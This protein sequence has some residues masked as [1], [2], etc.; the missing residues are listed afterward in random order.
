[1]EER[2]REASDLSTTILLVLVLELV[3]NP[4]QK[5]FLSPFLLLLF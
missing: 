2:G 3:V 1:M 4:V 5:Q